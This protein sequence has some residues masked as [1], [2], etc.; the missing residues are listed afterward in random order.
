M[1]DLSAIE[2]SILLSRR[3]NVHGLA[4]SAKDYPCPGSLIL[5]GRFRAWFV[6]DYRVTEEVSAS[7]F[8]AKLLLSL[9]VISG[10]A[11]DDV[12]VSLVCFWLRL[13]GDNLVD[14]LVQDGPIQEINELLI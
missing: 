13:G 11:K 6:S 5:L 14:V 4:L 3:V 7:T 12:L 1:A 9:F 8:K 10:D 2:A